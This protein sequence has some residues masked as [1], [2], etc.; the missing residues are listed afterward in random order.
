ML[1][2]SKTSKGDYEEMNLKCCDE[3]IEL[4]R[5]GDLKGLADRVNDI[6][7]WEGIPHHYFPHLINARKYEL[8]KESGKI[9]S[10]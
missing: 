7:Y 3:L 2:R 4:E 9:D 1:R 5:K 8:L 10:N 6:A